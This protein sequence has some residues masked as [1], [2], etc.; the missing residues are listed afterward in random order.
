LVVWY[1]L[2]ETFC[3]VHGIDFVPHKF[4]QKYVTSPLKI[5]T[6]QFGVLLFFVIS[7]FIITHVALRETRIEFVLKRFFRIWPPMIVGVLAYAALLTFAESIG[8]PI[9]G[10]RS[11]SF[12]SV[13]DS[14]ILINGVWNGAFSIH[15]LVWSLVLELLFY[16]TTLAIMPLLKG[17]PATVVVIELIGYVVLTATYPVAGYERPTTLLTLCAPLF[18]GQAIYLRWAGKIGGSTTIAFLAAWLILGEWAVQTH[19]ARYIA[20]YPVAIWRVL[21]YLVFGLLLALEAK[22]G[23]QRI[24]MLSSEISYSLYLLH[25]PVGYGFLSLTVPFIP[26][27]IA[28]VLALTATWFASWGSYK[29]IERPS[30]QLAR[31]LIVK[32]GRTMT[33]L[34]SRAEGEHGSEGDEQQ[35]GRDPGNG[36]GG[37][38]KAPVAV[39]HD[40]VQTG[41]RQGDGPRQEARNVGGTAD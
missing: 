12:R 33:L 32:M 13:A 8:A 19:S 36:G 25:V 10:L 27:P 4:A 28:L 20:Q 14:M 9:E 2:I 23:M 39:V 40:A 26:Y 5:D 21:A 24:V 37:E 6:G 38:G 3:R 31:T 15:P 7:G 16:L 34:G 35:Y 11:P 18:V 30:Q 41:D 22:L 1:H 17:W 29:V